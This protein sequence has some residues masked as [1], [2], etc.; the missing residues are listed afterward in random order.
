MKNAPYIALFAAI[1]LALAATG[2]S[3]S[4]AC[5][6]DSDCF[7]G[8]VCVDDVCGEPRIF[9][10]THDA[11]RDDGAQSSPDGGDTDAGHVVDAGPDE[12]EGVGSEDAGPTDP[13]APGDTGGAMGACIVDPFTHTC[14]DDEYEP[15]NQWIDGHRM[16]QERLGCVVDW[17]EHELTASA[18]VCQN[19]G[20]DFYFVEYLPCDFDWILE[21]ELDHGSMCPDELVQFEPLSVDCDDQQVQCIVEDGKS[22]IRLIVE[23]E[24]VN[25]QVL[26]VQVHTGDRSDVAFPYEITVR[27]RR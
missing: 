10:E 15:N 24:M 21:F 27:S 18:Q 2:C 5:S 26:Y 22:I 12:D 11:S 14:I 23:K 20:S 9:D 6:T 19:D 25:S 13:D 7:S 3:G 1:P 17:Q 4:Q 8:E 16:I